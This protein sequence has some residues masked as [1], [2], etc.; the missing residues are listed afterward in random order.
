MSFA[1]TR[2]IDA[3]TEGCSSALGALHVDLKA[4][5]AVYGVDKCLW[6]DARF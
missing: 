6:Y 3:V 2:H 1:A 5:V 4:V